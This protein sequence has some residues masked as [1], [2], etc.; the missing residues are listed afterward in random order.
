M[1]PTRD[2]SEYRSVPHTLQGNEKLSSSGGWKYS[3]KAAS[4][5]DICSSEPRS[6]IGSGNDRSSGGDAPVFLVD[7][8][9]ALGLPGGDFPAVEF[10]GGDFLLAGGGV[11]YRASWPRFAGV[12]VESVIREE[13][14]RFAA[15]ENC[16]SR[17]FG[18]GGFSGRRGSN[19]RSSSNRLRPTDAGALA[20]GDGFGEDCFEGAAWAEG[21]DD[22]MLER[23][24]RSSAIVVAGTL[25]DSVPRFDGNEGET[26]GSFGISSSMSSTPITADGVSRE[27]Q[28]SSSFLAT[29][30][31]GTKT[32]ALQPG[33]CT[34]LPTTLVLAFNRF[35]HCGQ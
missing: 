10:P 2:T 11:V 29:L 24:L 15:E 25:F 13:S 1:D 34:F 18:V 22:S 8:P 12:P 3:R 9:A 5:R 17:G 26:V 23:L 6:T 19:S 21:V 33:H 32:L 4:S 7:K 14:L 30:T 28:S 31:P 16:E 27:N 35:W 20:D